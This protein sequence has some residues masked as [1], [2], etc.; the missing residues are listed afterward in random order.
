MDPATLATAVIAILTP[1]V[2]KTAKEVIEAAGQLGYDKAKKL[3]ETLK[4][5]W[6]GDPVAADHL[7]RFEKKP[8]VHA[9][10]L[11]ELVQEK[12]QTDPQLAADVAQTVKEIGPQ[13]QVFIKMADAENLTGLDVG[14][15]TGNANAKVTLDLE[16]GKNVTG[17]KIGKLG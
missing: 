6:S 15:M 14:E 10:A 2:T 8:E 7:Q 4:L 1:Y 13:L 5:R 17:A 11:Q 3:L 12:L 9:P 16:K